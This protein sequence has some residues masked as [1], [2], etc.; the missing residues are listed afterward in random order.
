[1]APR[2]ASDGICVTRLCKEVGFDCFRF[3]GYWEECLGGGLKWWQKYFQTGD[4]QPL[5]DIEGYY[6]ID[7]KVTKCVYEY[8]VEH[9]MVKIDDGSETPVEVAVNWQ[10]E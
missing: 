4:N 9:G 10:G 8:G 2:G 3:F 1:M 5:I 7:V 6:A